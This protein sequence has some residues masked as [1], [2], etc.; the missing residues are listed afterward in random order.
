MVQGVAFPTVALSEARWVDGELH[1]R[2]DPQSQSV[3]GQETSFR[4]VGLDDA[5]AWTLNGPGTTA[6]TGSDVIVRTRVDNVALTLRRALK[7]VAF[8][9]QSRLSSRRSDTTVGRASLAL[10]ASMARRS[11]PDSF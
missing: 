2:L 7:T 1:L 4:I 9:L 6:V 8:I 5:A 10:L 3:T 11:R